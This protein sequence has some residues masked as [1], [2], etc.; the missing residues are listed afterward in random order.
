M[1]WLALFAAFCPLPAFALSCASWT[2]ADAFDAAQSSE[3][4]YVVVEGDLSFDPAGVPKTD[5]ENPIAAPQ[6]TEI[7]ARLQ[8][9]SLTRNGFS[10]PFDAA[11][12][13][14]IACAGPWCANVR[15]G[16]S[17][18]FLVR[19][20]G[21]FTLTQGPCGGMLFSAPSSADIRA[22]EQKHDDTQSR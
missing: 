9:L 11:L 5:W 2:L 6:S 20:G 18:A 7:A 12:T 4:T 8:G 15:Q 1:K 13:F 16:P 3:A 17:L 10:A 21:R 19:E 22:I 14:K